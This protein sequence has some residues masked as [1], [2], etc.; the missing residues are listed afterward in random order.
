MKH[1]HEREQNAISS[2]EIIY[3]LILE[4]LD[5][6]YRIDHDDNGIVENISPGVQDNKRNSF[7]YLTLKEK[8]QLFFLFY[9]ITC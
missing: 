8:M 7:N 6:S 5:V 1:Q 3:H 9:P 2:N 4:G